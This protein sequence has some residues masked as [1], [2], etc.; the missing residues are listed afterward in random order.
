[1]SK[2]SKLIR[3]IFVS[4][5][6]I[7]SF[8]TAVRADDE[9]AKQLHVRVFDNGECTFFKTSET[10]VGQLLEENGIMLEENDNI[11]KDLSELVENE[12]RINIER[13]KVVKITI[14]NK[15]YKSFKTGCETI[16]ELMSEMGKED[17]TEYILATPKFS[18]SMKIEDEIEFEISSVKTEEIST[19]EEIPFET[20]KKEDNSL[21]KGTEK[22]KTKG[23]KGI[24]T[25]T[26]K[27]V[28]IGG[29]LKET[30]V[31]SEEI[32]K[33]AVDEVIL[34]GTYVEPEKPAEPQPQ[35]I[36]TSA[37]TF[38]VKKEMTM[39]ATGY[40]AYAPGCGLYT[41]T[42]AVAKKGVVAVDKS[43]IPLGTKLYID[44]YGVAIAADT[45]GAIKGDRIDLC[46]D[47]YNQAVQFGRNNVKVYIIG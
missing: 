7:T 2:K 8:T 9:V 10:T 3:N 1:M 14:D 21:K 37:G 19:N 35:T 13:A 26:F 39:R 6:V 44:G 22:V 25:T 42:G 46:F 34:I 28:Y 33:E 20:V 24:K 17:G 47:N 43:V 11:D 23:E 31:I 4:V 45:G 27:N 38:N 15:T 12:M 32:T 16:G 30:T 41:A 5:A 29:E 36:K 18:S 40:C